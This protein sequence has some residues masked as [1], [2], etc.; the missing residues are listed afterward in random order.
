MWKEKL[1]K[2]KKIK[3]SIKIWLAIW[4][5]ILV[6]AYNSLSA[7]YWTLSK[8][9]TQIGEVVKIEWDCA[10]GSIFSMETNI[11]LIQN[12]D[13]KINNVWETKIREITTNCENTWSINLISTEDGKPYFMSID[14]F[15]MFTLWE[16]LFVGAILFI[17]WFI[18]FIKK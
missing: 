11:W 3:S 16:L 12:T 9:I 13:I 15:N 7:E 18:L 4:F 10:S 2:R 14:D 17:S 6:I 8:N 5:L 1:E